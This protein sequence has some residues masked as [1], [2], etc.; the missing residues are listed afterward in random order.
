MANLR[1]VG[2]RPIS[3]SDLESLHIDSV[4]G[5]NSPAPHRAAS[6]PVPNYFLG[7]DL[8]HMA[9]KTSI[10]RQTTEPG[11]FYCT[12]SD[13]RTGFPARVVLGWSSPFLWGRS[14]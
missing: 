5:K 12:G 14:R 6:M 3:V 1:G 8:V 2:I 13:G 10:A 7:R 11:L 9:R 4:N